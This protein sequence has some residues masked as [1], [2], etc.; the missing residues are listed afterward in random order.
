MAPPNSLLLYDNAPEQ[1]DAEAQVLGGLL[2]VEKSI[3]P[4]YF[5]DEKGSNLFTEITRQPE[6][7]LTRT[8]LAL[9]RENTAEIGELVGKDALLIEYGSGSSEK[10]RILLERL[11]PKVYAPIDI[12]RNYLTKAADALNEEYSWLEVRAICQDYTLEFDLP[13]VVEARP[14]AFFPGSSIGNFSRDEALQFL[15]RVKR[16]VGNTGGLLIGVDLKKDA[17]VLN[18]AYNDA[19][20]VTEKFNLNVL[21]HLNSEFSGNF[22]LNSFSH[23][24]EYNA[25][26]GCIEMFLKSK[27][28]QVVN[29]AGHEIYLNEGETIHTENSHKYSLAEFHDLADA[30]G[31]V[32]HR[33]W[34]DA[35]NWFAVFYL[36]NR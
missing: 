1:E 4:K 28:D 5:Y 12:S 17:R 25:R 16:L 19:N 36:S 34:C 23:L 13:F 27:S 21:C 32:Q 31:F 15:K 9:L 2:A 33:Y 22:N 6:Y 30:A 26:E 3:S 14:V 29:L 10:V 20:G 35:R 7:Y 18:A 8:E 24:A 11:Q